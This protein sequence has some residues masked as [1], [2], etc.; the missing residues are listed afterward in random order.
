MYC[1]A[2]HG[3]S[4]SL[5]AEC[6]VLNNY[7]QK[8]LS[9]CKFGQDKPTCEKCPV[10]CYAPEMREKIRVVMKYSGPRMIFFYPRS[11]IV[12]LFKSLIISRKYGF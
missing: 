11:A 4:H 6:E 8:R 3:T 12:H 5:C 7:A 9:Y 10:H 1:A 2:K